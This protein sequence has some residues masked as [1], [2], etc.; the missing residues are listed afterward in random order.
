L[1]G[2]EGVM[3]PR[4]LDLFC[5]GGGAS[6]GYHRAGFD[7]TGVDIESQPRYPFAFVQADALAYVAAH[8]HEYDAIAAS[9]P[10]QAFTTLRVMPNASDHADLL[11]PTRALLIATGLPYVIENVPGASMPSACQMCGSSFGLGVAVAGEWRQ[12]RRHRWFESNVAMLVPPCA[13]RGKTIGFYGDHARLGRR[14]KGADGSK[15]DISDASK[16]RLGRVALG[17]PWMEWHE[18]TQAIPP[19][20][21]EWVGTQLLR[22]LGRERAA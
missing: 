7:V 14:W 8:G 20:F 12:V 15:G 17:V 9:P 18:I 6:M 21:T 4:L 11:T 16:V 1:G 19:A 13:H 2:A 22:A 10:C 3:R 5:G